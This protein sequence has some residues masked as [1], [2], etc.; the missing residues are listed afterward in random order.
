MNYLRYT[1][2]FLT[3]AIGVAL[4]VMAANAWLDAGLGSSA[5]LLAPA[6]IAALIEGRAFVRA[7]TRR[8]NP[9][10]A[11]NFA[12]LA[13]VLAVALNVALSYAMT[14][15]LPEFARLTIAP[16]GSR[17]F[18]LLLGIYALGYLLS[19]R[20]LLGLGARSELEAQARRA[21]LGKP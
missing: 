7:E 1:A 12:I 18:L 5:Q 3:V 10:E 14:A 17:Q 16:F 6:M 20:F 19:N 8:P 13:T 15:L 4:I 11:W 2:V 21:G 9:A